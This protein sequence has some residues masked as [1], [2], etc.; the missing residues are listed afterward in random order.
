MAKKF[1]LVEQLDAA[2]MHHWCKR[3]LRKGE[4]LT[5]VRG[6]GQPS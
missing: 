1:I 5:L 2:G 3:K 4:V 6:A